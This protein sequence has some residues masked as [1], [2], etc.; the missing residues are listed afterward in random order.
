MGWLGL[1]Y[2]CDVPSLFDLNI[3][4]GIANGAQTYTLLT[5]LRRVLYLAEDSMHFS[6][7]CVRISTSSTS[8]LTRPPPPCDSHLRP[9]L[10][11]ICFPPRG[12]PGRG[13]PLRLFFNERDWS[14]GPAPVVQGKKVGRFW[15]GEAHSTERNPPGADSKW[16]PSLYP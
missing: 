6:L 11:E 9:L 8:S 7:T 5:S 3:I 1:P 12:V 10:P 16:L 15:T 4:F 2:F 13:F 14:W